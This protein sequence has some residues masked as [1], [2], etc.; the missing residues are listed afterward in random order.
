MYKKLTVT[1][2][3]TLV[4]LIFASSV[5]QAEKLNDKLT[6]STV[7]RYRYMVE[8]PY[9]KATSNYFYFDRG[10]VT[11]RYKYSDNIAMRYTLDFNHRNYTDPQNGKL[12]NQGTNARIK[13]AYIQFK[14]FLGVQGLEMLFGNYEQPGAQSYHNTI[15]NSWIDRFAYVSGTAFDNGYSSAV[16][17][18]MA[19]YNLPASLGVKGYARLA[20]A[21]KNTYSFAKDDNKA[22]NVIADIWLKPVAGLSVFGWTMTDYY[23]KASNKDNNFWIGGGA[24]YAIDKKLDVGVEVTNGKKNVEA[25]KALDGVSGLT[26]MGYVNYNILPNLMF[27]GE[28]GQL[29][30]N[31]DVDNDEW[32]MIL[33]GLNYKIIGENY[34]MFNVV[35]DGF[36]VGDES[37]GN[38]RF[39]TQFWVEF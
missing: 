25:D 4:V 22:K 16:T 24:E 36:K 39:V 35:R 3:L 5:A 34:L 9:T 31:G 20:V 33:A 28:Y 38:L 26:Y 1:I 27:V 30:P 29:D 23:N 21:N 10:Y 12:L 13:Y 2:L 17:G 37:K 32:N 19:T 18:A 7:L 14:N 8:Q 6:F 11:M 15:E